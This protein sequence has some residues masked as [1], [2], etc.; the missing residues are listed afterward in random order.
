M[1]KLS[2]LILILA[3]LSVLS[4]GCRSSRDAATQQRPAVEAVSGKTSREI[5]R[6]AERWI[7]TPYRY[8][9]TERG[10]GTDCSGMVMT[11]FGKAG[12]T[13]P[14]SSAEQ[15]K[16]CKPVKKNDLRA[17]DLVFFTSS[18]SGSRV[19]HVGVYRGNGEFIHAST[20]HGVIVSRL[21][22]NYYQK[23]YHSAGRVGGK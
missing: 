3:L 9:G 13:L 18:R 4:P 8:G 2:A 16:Y 21:D 19:T 22:E 15:Q 10:R 12:I 23:H 14:R 11:V 17:G 7:G 5:V 6:E 20:S 1:Q